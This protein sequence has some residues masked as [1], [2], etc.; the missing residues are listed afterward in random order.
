MAQSPF[1]KHYIYYTIISCAC[2]SFCEI[3]EP[4]ARSV[5]GTAYTVW[6]PRGRYW[7]D[8]PVGNLVYT[9]CEGGCL[10]VD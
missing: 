6:D 10:R 7:P 4:I 9:Q 3:F 1:L 2:Q 8:V 5:L